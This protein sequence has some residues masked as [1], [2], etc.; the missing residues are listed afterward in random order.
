MDDEVK[1]FICPYE[2]HGE[3]HY[4]TIRATSADEAQRILQNIM[5]TA[6]L[7]RPYA[8]RSFKKHADTNVGELLERF[9]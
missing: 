8:R 7:H 9:R 5:P 6:I 2:L 4:P 3:T 1:P